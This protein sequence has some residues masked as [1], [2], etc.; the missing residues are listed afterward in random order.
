MNDQKSPESDASLSES[1]KSQG[2]ESTQPTQSTASDS[3]LY[4]APS[5]NHVELLQNYTLTDYMDY[6]SRILRI[7]NEVFI[8]AKGNNMRTACSLCHLLAANKIAVI[9]SMT[10]GMDVSA[11]FSSGLQKSQPIPMMTFKLIR[12]ELG[13]YITSEFQQKKLVEIFEKYDPNLTGYVD[14][15]SIKLL[16][17]GIKFKANQEEINR[18]N[19]FL[20]ESGGN[21]KKLNLPNFIKYCSILIHPLLKETVIRKIFAQEFEQKN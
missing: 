11:A 18:A 7:E 12:G 16:K 3:S 14:I 6:I 10:T 2:T 9:Q 20:T 4:D 19:T 1:S 17:I 15:K 5:S 21:D 8:S 13:K